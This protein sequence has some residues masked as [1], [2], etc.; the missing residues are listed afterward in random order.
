[1][2][3]VSLTTA[4][5]DLGLVPLN[6]A[7]TT[8]QKIADEAGQNVSIRDPISDKRLFTVPPRKVFGK[9]SRKK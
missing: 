7:Q 3:A 8:A 6:Q 4:T 9:A 2:T 5:D 1:M